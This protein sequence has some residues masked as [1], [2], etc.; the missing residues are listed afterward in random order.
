MVGGLKKFR[1]GERRG[2]VKT[3]MVK[4]KWRLKY[5][6]RCCNGGEES[7][8]GNKRMRLKDQ[9][10]RSMTILKVEIGRGRLHHKSKILHIGSSGNTWR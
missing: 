1:N 8:F 6:T 4:F 10:I 5:P 7:W 9:K 3:K 2:L